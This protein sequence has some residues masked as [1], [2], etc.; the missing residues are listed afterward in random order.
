M[1]FHWVVVYLVG[2][3]WNILGLQLTSVKV[4]A[5]YNLLWS[6]GKVFCYPLSKGSSSPSLVYIYY[7]INIMS[8]PKVNSYIYLT[9]L[10]EP[11]L[12]KLLYVLPFFL[13][14]V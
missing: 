2:K 1:L 14:I 13:M 8:I 11:I 10:V 6:S 5:F 9:F 7:F 12:C 3:Q 4:G